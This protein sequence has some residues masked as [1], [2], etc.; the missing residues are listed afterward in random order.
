MPAEASVKLVKEARRC[1]KDLESSKATAMDPVGGSRLCFSSPYDEETVKKVLRDIRS[2]FEELHR[3]AESP[4]LAGKDNIPYELKEE[5]LHAFQ[6]RNKQS[7]CIYHHQRLCL[8]RHQYWNA[9]PGSVN[10]SHGLESS[11]SSSG[12]RTESE[13]L[14]KYGELCVEYMQSFRDLDLRA[15]L[16]PPKDLF[17]QVRVVQDC[18]QVE[19]ENG[20]IYLSKNSHHYLRRSDIEH[21]I[22]KGFLLV[23]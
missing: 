18:G 4:E 13:F 8:L 2:N 11:A 3:L 7:L 6:A 14:R 20:S 5:I 19:I 1:K 9:G 16:T 17:C 10:N 15:N 22:E 21:L 23:V 12:S